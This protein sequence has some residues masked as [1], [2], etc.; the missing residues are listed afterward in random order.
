MIRIADE[1]DIPSINSLLE[2]VLLVH[3]TGRP[4]I[5]KKEGAKYTDAELKAIIE[6]EFTPVFVYSEEGRI[7]GHCFCQIIDRQEGNSTYAYKTLYVDD[8]CVDKSARGKGIGKALMDFVKE[9]AKKNN[10]YNITLHA[11]ECNPKAVKFYESLGMKIQQ[12]TFEDV[13]DRGKENV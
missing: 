11:W 1:K 2:Q 13:I 7:L 4:D 10:F 6:D 8:L 9:Y 5:F 3:H 12:Y